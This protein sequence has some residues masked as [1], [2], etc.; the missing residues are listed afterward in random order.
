VGTFEMPNSDGPPTKYM[1]AFDQSGSVRWTVEGYRPQIATADGEVIATDD[2]GAAAMFDQ[3]G[4]ATGQM[5]TLPVYSWLRNAYQ[6]GS[7]EDILP[8]FIRVATGNGS[9]RGGSYSQNLTYILLD[10][11]PVLDFAPRTQIDNAL[12]N[13]LARLAIPTVRTYSDQCVFGKLGIDKYGNRVTTDGLIKF[14]TKKRPF[15]SDATRSTFCYDVLTGDYPLS[16]CAFWGSGFWLNSVAFVMN[17][18]PG[19]EAYT[20]TPYEYLMTF[21]RPTAI[22]SSTL[23]NEAMLFHEAIHGYTG[24]LDLDIENIFRVGPPSNNISV[25]IKG[26]VL[27]PQAAGCQ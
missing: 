6:V 7:V 20:Y 12:S 24:R 21:F 5:G 25:Y 18:T 19:D 9:F 23:D 1:V 22:S 3:N 15:F 2:S 8:N 26:N 4:N 10:W 17:N 14:L 16:V 13:L 27:G 11:F